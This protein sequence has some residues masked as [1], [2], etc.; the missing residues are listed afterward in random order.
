MAL[1]LATHLTVSSFNDKQCLFVIITV[2]KECAEAGAMLRRRVDQLWL[3]QRDAC[4]QPLPDLLPLSHK[5][6][7][8]ILFKEQDGSPCMEPEHLRH[9]VEGKFNQT[10]DSNKFR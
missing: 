1:G 10:D 6:T 8:K 9:Y 4:R 3:V 7:S 2:S 5:N